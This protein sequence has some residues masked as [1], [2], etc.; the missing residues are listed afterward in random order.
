MLS[1]SPAHI[2]HM[3]VFTEGSLVMFL[4]EVPGE[5]AGPIETPKELGHE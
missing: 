1:I 4:N 3:D 2:Q 5:W